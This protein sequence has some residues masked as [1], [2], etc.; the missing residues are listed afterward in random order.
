MK[1][2]ESLMQSTTCAVCGIAVYVEGSKLAIPYSEHFMWFGTLY[3]HY[4]EYVQRSKS[5]TCNLEHSIWFG[6]LYMHYA[7]YVVF[8]SSNY[9]L[10]H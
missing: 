5:R 10:E 7:V 2:I 3:M 6:T 4:T 8:K 9:N 1:S